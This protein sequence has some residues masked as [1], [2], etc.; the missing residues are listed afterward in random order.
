MFGNL[1][2]G[3]VC[4]GK[5]MGHVR[6]A[7]GGDQREGAK[8]PQPFSPAGNQHQSQFTSCSSYFNFYASAAED[9]IKV[10]INLS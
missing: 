2:R 6:W 7:K 1:F 9:Y 3:K 4:W 8:S 10:K 5:L